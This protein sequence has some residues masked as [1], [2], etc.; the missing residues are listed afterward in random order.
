MAFAL[1]LTLNPHAPQLRRGVR[2]SLEAAHRHQLLID[3][4]DKKLTAVAQINLLDCHEVSFLLLLTH[5]QRE[6]SDGTAM[7]CEYRFSM[8]GSVTNETHRCDDVP[9]WPAEP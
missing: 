8:F 7:K 2:E 5:A 9:G 4:T 6:S 1:K 3:E